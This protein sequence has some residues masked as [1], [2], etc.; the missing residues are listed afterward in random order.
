MNDLQQFTRRRPGFTLVELLVVI[1]IIAL[2]ISILLPVLGRARE[3]ANRIKCSSNQRSI[4]QAAFIRTAELGKNAPL[5]PNSSGANDTLGHIVPKYIKDPNIGIC[6]GTRNGI[7]PNVLVSAA[8]SNAEYGGFPILEDIH[9]VASSAGDD[10]GHS[11][12]IFNSYSNGVWPGRTLDSRFDMLIKRHGK[13][14]RPLDTILIL[15]SDQDPSGDFFRMNNWPNVGNNHGDKGLN[16]GFGD[17]SV[18]WMPRGEALI[19]AYITGFQGAAQ[20]NVFTMKH[21]P[22][23]VITT[24]TIRG[25][26]F[27]KYTF[28]R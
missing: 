9:R 17:G 18:R 22:G 21:C 2:L 7:R 16:M 19:R 8:I 15:D 11:Y 20:N 1:G 26:S 25:K 23:L 6:P 28:T 24:T 14:L 5:F 4:L 3:A 10:S 13:L 12:E 27:T